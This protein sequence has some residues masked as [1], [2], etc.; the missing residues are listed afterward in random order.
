MSCIEKSVKELRDLLSLSEKSNTI[1]SRIN[2][3]ML[4]TICVKCLWIVYIH[5]CL[6]LFAFDNL[7]ILRFRFSEFNSL[8]NS[9]FP[10]NKQYSQR[11]LPILYYI[12][13]WAPFTS[14][15]LH[16]IKTRAYQTLMAQLFIK[17]YVNIN[18]IFD[19]LGITMRVSC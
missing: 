16:C 3:E 18:S 5:W 19:D 2:L 17:Y 14:K 10:V 6:L 7:E 11:A 4:T 1:A 9:D 15:I 12:A 13:R 8:K